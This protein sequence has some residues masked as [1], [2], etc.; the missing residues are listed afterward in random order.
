MICVV[1]EAIDA[2]ADSETDA[3]TDSSEYTIGPATYRK[4][5]RF[6]TKPGDGSGSGYE[7][8]RSYELT[9][10]REEYRGK[11][12]VYV[13]VHRLLALV[14]PDVVDE[15]IEYA[16]EYLDG[17]DV[18]HTNGCKWDN[19]L[20]N[21]ELI[22]HGRHSSITQSELRQ[23]AKAQAAEAKRRR[24]EEAHADRLGAD[25][26]PGCG[27]ETETLATSDGERCLDCAMREAD[28]A[29]IEL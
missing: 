3:E 14:H 23:I 21:L 25:R 27:T 24:E 9:P 22:E 20:G 5:P 26:C 16:L 17:R 11:R 18:H 7:R 4:L 2:P 29:T 10:G 19:R 6:E 12:D 1:S 13:Y 15:P 8:I 28:G